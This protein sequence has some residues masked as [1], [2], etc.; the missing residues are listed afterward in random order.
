MLLNIEPCERE[1]NNADTFVLAFKDRR[2]YSRERPFENFS[3]G[4]QN[5]SAKGHALLGPG[6]RSTGG[7]LSNLWGGPTFFEDTAPNWN[8]PVSS[9]SMPTSKHCGRIFERLCRGL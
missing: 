8:G 2:R 5:G 9:V 4:G 3:E 6:G 7:Q 1:L